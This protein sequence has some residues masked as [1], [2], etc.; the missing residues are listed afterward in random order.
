MRQIASASLAPGLNAWKVLVGGRPYALT[1]A[2][3]AIHPKDGKWKKSKFLDSVSK[4]DWSVPQSWVTS[5]SFASDVAIAPL[6]SDQDC[7]PQHDHLLGNLP[8]QIDLF[9]RQPYDP[10]GKWSEAS[11]LAYRQAVANPSPDSA[12]WEVIDVGFRGMSGALGACHEQD[13]KFSF[14]GMLTRRATSIPH[15]TKRLLAKHLPTADSSLSV[16]YPMLPKT[17]NNPSLDLLLPW[18]NGMQIR[19]QSLDEEVLK[20]A[21]LEAILSVAALRRS[22]IL[23]SQEIQR[24]LQRENLIK[25]SDLVGAP[26]VFDDLTAPAV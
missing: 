13:S 19:I 18:L 2:H 1:A 26:V 12:L 4:L 25:I 22:L 15:K 23:P 8:R 16:D 20:K 21:D 3:V 7:L 17:T 9:F 10:N 24:I 5:Q 11:S 14:V 6:D